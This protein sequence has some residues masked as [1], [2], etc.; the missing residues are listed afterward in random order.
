MFSGLDD[1]ELVFEAL[2]DV[3]SEKVYLPTSV[4]GPQA[5][6]ATYLVI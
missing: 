6:Q 5:I 3:L 2:R 1:S 4:V